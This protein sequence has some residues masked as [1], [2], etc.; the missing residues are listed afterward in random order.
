MNRYSIGIEIDNAGRLEKNGEE[1]TSWFRRSYSDSDVFEGINR[2][3][4]TPSFWHRF[5]EEQV[6]LV[7]E[8][9]KLL[10]ESYGI[11]Q[12]LGHEEISPSR[13]VDPG[14]A[15]PLDKMLD[16]I[17][18]GDRHEDLAEE[19]TDQPGAGV[20]TANKLNIRSGPGTHADVSG[21]PLP[22]GT[23]VHIKDK[24]DEWYEVVVESQ[25]WVSKKFVKKV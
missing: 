18:R 19:V 24:T 21:D 6:A 5:T 10:V 8:I 20:V 17:L 7:E 2:N 15:F 13:K 4:S 11:H 14:P 22:K 16:R 25:G 23:V 12:I 1:Y 3:E 9:Y